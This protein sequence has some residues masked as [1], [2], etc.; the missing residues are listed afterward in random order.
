MRA[1]LDEEQSISMLAKRVGMSQ[2]TFQRR[3][4]TTTG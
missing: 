1:R 4:E 3:F 2:R